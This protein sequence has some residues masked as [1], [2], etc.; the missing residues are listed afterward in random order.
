MLK[1]SWFKLKCKNTNNATNVEKGE[2][3]FAQP[4]EF[5]PISRQCLRN[6][7]NDPDFIAAVTDT[8]IDLWTPPVIPKEKPKPEPKNSFFDCVVN[9]ICIIIWTTIAIVIV[10]TCV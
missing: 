8:E 9:S 10:I 4:I 2:K 5:S 3:N 1:T 6:I 7:F